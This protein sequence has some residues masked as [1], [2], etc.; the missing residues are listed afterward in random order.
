MSITMKSIYLFLSYRL[1]LKEFYHFRKENVKGFSYRSFASDVGTKSANYLSWLIEGSRNITHKLLPSVIEALHF[2]DEEEKEYFTLLVRFEQAKHQTERE[3]IW[4]LIIAKRA[5]KTVTSIEERR[6]EYFS[7]WSI[8]AIKEL[9][10]VKPFNPKE[11]EGYYRLGAMLRPR[12]TKMEARRAVK[13]LLAL[14]LIT[15][16]PNGTL[17]VKERQVSTGN[18]APGFFI[19]Q[20]HHQ[21]LE[22]AANSMDLFPSHQRDISGMTLSISV[23]AQNE[24]KK[25][26]QE[27]RKKITEIV[28]V[29]TNPDRVIQVNMQVF[30]LAE[31]PDE[32]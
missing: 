3:Q 18:E 2:N 9:L 8:V 16:A 28:S 11:E 29:D 20:F 6:Y 17:S 25:V 22:R 26:L 23:N 21:M 1:Y 13:T 10:N 7:D 15:Q 30:P 31:L 5:E 19:R 27:T 4:Q 12:I 14:G 24:I 32:N